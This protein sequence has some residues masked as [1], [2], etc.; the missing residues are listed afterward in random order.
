MSRHRWLA[1]HYR[2]VLTSAA[3]LVALLVLASC[4]KPPVRPPSP[5]LPFARDA[6]VVVVSDRTA[7]A[8]ERTETGIQVLV[9]PDKGVQWTDV[10]PADL[11]AQP[12]VRY[13]NSPAAS[14]RS[15]WVAFL[16]LAVQTKTADGALDYMKLVY[17][18]AD[19]GQNW[20]MVYN[21]NP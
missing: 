19:G 4:V 1:R 21:T 20:T 6:A 2:G 15:D 5:G 8:L 14:F 9:S 13:A 18:T 3:G 17:S 10:T 11:K 12:V 7:W 16:A